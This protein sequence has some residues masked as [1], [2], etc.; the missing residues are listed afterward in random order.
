MESEVRERSPLYVNRADDE[1]L[2]QAKK[3]I[4]RRLKRQSKAVA[5]PE[6]FKDMLRTRLAGQE[7]EIVL[8]VFLDMR[9]R[10]IDIEEMFYGSV[11]SCGVSVRVILVEAL[12]RNAAA[13]VLVP[14]HPSG[15]S[16][17]S[18]ADVDLTQR[19]RS[20]CGLL[21]IKLLDHVIVGETVTSLAEQ[22]LL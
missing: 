4:D 17:P 1:I 22:G 19:V 21:E 11:S 5:R 3:I 9:H 15:L 7:R 6:C 8:V 16:D 13:L 2:A 20:A 12:K 10:I 14:N 18:E